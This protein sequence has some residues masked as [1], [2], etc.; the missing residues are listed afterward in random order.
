MYIYFLL[1]GWILGVS[2]MGYPLPQYFSLL[3]ILGTGAN[4]LLILCQYFKYKMIALRSFKCIQIIFITII[5]G[6]IGWHYA[7]SKLEQR[8]IL[9]DISHDQIDKI[10]YIANINKVKEK[11]PSARAGFAKTITTTQQKV[12]LL[13]PQQSMQLLLYANESQAKQLQLGQYYR[14]TGQIKPIHGFAVDGVFDKEKWSIQENILGTLSVQS[15]ELIDEQQVRQSGYAAF[16]EQQHGW[17][18]Q[19][20]LK[21]EQLRLDFRALI[22]NSSLDNPGLLLALLTG[23]ESLLSQAT[24]DLF[25]NLGISHLLAISGP[26]VLVFAALFSFIIHLII[27]RICPSIFLRIP[28]PY[29]LLYPFLI[30]VVFYTAFVGFEIPALR[31]MLTVFILSLIILFK[32]K[33]Q[34][35]QH[36]LL[37]ASIL[38]LIDPFSILSAAFALS[39]GTCFILIRVYQTIQQQDH[40][41]IQTW[42][43]QIKR[44]T[45]ILIELQWKI[46]LALMPLVLWIF[47]QFSWWAPISNLLAIP[48]ISIIVPIEIVAACLSII[49]E[50]MGLWVFQFADV[51]LSMLVKGLE[52]LDQNLHLDL[53]W[54][55]LNRLEI[56][57]IALALFILF[58][59]QGVVPKFWALLCLCPLFLPQQNNSIFQLNVIDVGQG[60]AIFINL[61]QHKMLIDTGGSWDETQFSIRQQ[62]MLPYLMRQGINQLDQVVLTHLDQDH[63]AAFAEIIKRIRVNKVYSNEKNERLNKQDFAYCHQGQTWQ[64]EQIQI[65]VLSPPIN[66]LSQAV[67]QKN[68][69]S[70]VIYIQVPQSKSYQ[71]FLFMGDAG[72]E[73]EFHLLQQYPELKVDVLILGHH[74]SQNSSSY[75]FL[76]QLQPKLAIV[77]AGYNN[78][79]GHPHP[80]VLKRLEALNIPLKSTIKQGTI[81]FNIDRSGQVQINSTRQKL[82][83]FNGYESRT[84]TD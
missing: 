34:P 62:V 42:Q 43:M 16:V 70:C 36:L 71:H 39:F 73:T 68:E 19:A 38:L 26:H 78:R 23:D 18:Q 67:Y 76:K 55:A 56:F 75:A 84:I 21:I 77:S 8:L 27:K 33:I 80:I 65:S 2:L 82:K 14:V 5:S 37:T 54:W 1:I 81:Q 79:Y 4:S 52:I 69:Q 17:W 45:Y 35:L 51:L 83:W 57:C 58:V 7:D 12:L 44:F 40:Q 47:Q 48:M 6:L 22:A 24:Q 59:P 66:K 13:A 61:P 74:G 64:Y 46:F 10:I 72:W 49:F 9:R 50:P 28:R 31:T 53:S 20:Q 29:V 41:Q 63:S 15:I 3:L 32:Q 60:Q 25:R 30:G 11:T